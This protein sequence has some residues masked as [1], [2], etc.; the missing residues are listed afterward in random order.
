MKTKANA[1]QRKCL[2][3][4]NDEMHIIAHDY[5]IH[6][7]SI[8]AIVVPALSVNFHVISA[9]IREFPNC[10]VFSFNFFVVSSP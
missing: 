6:R 9:F 4:T 1:G 2:F 3:I 8:S 10:L 7:H 5:D